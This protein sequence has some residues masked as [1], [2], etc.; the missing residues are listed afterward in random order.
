[1][2]IDGTVVIDIV[3]VPAPSSFA[4]FVVALGGLGFVA[5]R[6]LTA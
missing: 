6:R 5:R 3:Q 4:L 2:E 1:M